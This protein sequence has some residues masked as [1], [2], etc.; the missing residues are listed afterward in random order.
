MFGR[1]VLTFCFMQ[2]FSPKLSGICFKVPVP[3]LDQKL[4]KFSSYSNI[5]NRYKCYLE[6]DFKIQLKQDPNEPTQ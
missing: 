4:L 6:G 1:T 3:N 2:K 5:W